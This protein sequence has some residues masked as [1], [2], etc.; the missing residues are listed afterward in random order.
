MALNHFIQPVVPDAAA[1]PV[2]Y[3]AGSGAGDQLTQAEVGKFVKLVATDRY[4]NC[5]VGDD[6]EGAVYAVELA[7]Q[8]GFTIASVLNARGTRMH[9]TF[10]GLQAT[11]GTGAIAA[12]DYVVC[13]TPVAKGTAL[14]RFPKV[15][16]RT[17]Q[18]GGTLADLA[19]ATA[20]LKASLHAWRVVSLGSAATGAVGTVGVIERV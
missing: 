19:A 8:N 4:D 1:T 12:G 14:T 3:G 7:P 6:I 5:D 9:V 16:K 17:V 2:R 10:D 11:P 15:C 18:P 20:A 13:G